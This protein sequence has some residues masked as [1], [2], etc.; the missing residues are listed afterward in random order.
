M[1]SSGFMRPTLK[2]LSS[3]FPDLGSCPECTGSFLLTA[4]SWVQKMIGLQEKGYEG[5]LAWAGGCCVAK[6]RRPLGELCR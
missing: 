2:D 5:P 3:L 4:A 1:A 6:S